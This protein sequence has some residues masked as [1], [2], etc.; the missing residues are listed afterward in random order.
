[1][2]I[3]CH[4]SGLSVRARARVGGSSLLGPPPP[5]F[6]LAPLFPPGPPTRS[7]HCRAYYILLLGAPPRQIYWQQ[8]QYQKFNTNHDNL[9]MRC[10]DCKRCARGKFQSGGADGA[11]TKGAKCE[12]CPAGWYIPPMTK[13]TACYKCPAGKHAPETPLTVIEACAVDTIKSVELC[14]NEGT[15]CAGCAAGKYQDKEGQS[16]C[17]TCP[18]GFVS[19]SDG[20]ACSKCPKGMYTGAGWE[21]CTAC[22]AGHVL[23]IAYAAGKM[24]RETQ[25]CL[26]LGVSFADDRCHPR[27]CFVSPQLCRNH[28]GHG[29]VYE[30]PS[31]L[32]VYQRR[33]G[34]V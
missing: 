23:N 7:P 32:H 26:C 3:S 15:S 20:K 27:W 10:H 8:D 29:R 9:Y 13:R 14:E 21:A 33:H 6:F 28:D 12:P 24:Y 5:L 16:V 30:G 22:P 4:I 25:V 2:T 11:C 18:A 31:R 17:K 1:M 34:G 19:N